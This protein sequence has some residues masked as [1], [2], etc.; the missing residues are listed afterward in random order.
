MKL[1]DKLLKHLKTDRNTFFTY[2]LTLISAYIIIDRVVEMIIMIFTGMGVD[3]W[4]PFVYTLAI[5]CPVFAYLFSCSSKYASND[6]VKHKLFNIFIVAFYIIVVS[7]F[8]QWLNLAG[9]ML[10]LSVPRFTDIVTNFYSLI[11]P[12]FSAIALYIPLTT[13]YG[14]IKW[15]VGTVNDTKDITDSLEDYGGINLSDKSASW[16]SYTC[17]MVFGKDKENGS[18]VKIAEEKRFYPT[19]VAGVSGSGKTSMIFEPMVAQDIDKKY[20]FKEISKEMGFTALKTGLATLNCPYSNDYINDNFSL[21]ML[22]PN[23]NKVGTYNTYM[24]KMII[25]NAGD[26]YIYKNLGI[27]YIS[28][29]IESVNHIKKVLKAY[30]LKYNLLDPSDS[31]SIGLNPFIYD[32]P[33][34]IAIAISLILKGT[35]VSVSDDPQY[36]FMESASK[37]IIENLVI[38]LKET[39]PIIHEGYLPTLE[40]LFECLNNYSKIEEL[41]EVLKSDEVLAKKYS[42]VIVF[43]ERYFYMSS[44]HNSDLQKYAEFVSAQLESLIRYPGVRNILCNRTNNVNFDNA[45]KDGEITLVCTRRGDLGPSI[46]RLFGLFVILLMQ[47]SV[48]RRTGDEK[49]RIPHF[50]YIDEFADFVCDETDTLFTLYRKYKV[51]TVVSIQNLAQLDGPTYGTNKKHRQVIT[52]N[53]S[54]K[55]VFGNN[56]PEDNEWWSQEIGDKKEW[57]YGNSYNTDKGEYDP[58]L[59]GIKY[60]NKI[61]YKPG[62]IQAVKFKQ[63]IYKLRNLSGKSDTGIA[64]LNFLSSSYYEDKKVKQYKFD[65]FNI[66]GSHIQGDDIEEK[67]NKKQNLSKYHFDDEDSATEVDPIKTDTSD[68]KFLF[69]NED[70][71]VINLKKNN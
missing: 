42:S 17:E 64:N 49:T 63:C 54:N 41:C 68:S 58:K 26:K 4:N 53:C 22:S 6:G 11:R 71:I 50:L 31:D 52:A 61:K 33:I 30:K 60:A 39:F 55:F 29:D 59:T 47:H 14:V 45:L 20:F 35:A 38:L 48:L 10:L 67:I 24:K 69:D 43:L 56:S 66:T 21:N 44:S 23:E 70:A 51:S 8:T 12:A 36:A 40:D 16:G 32:D 34:Q 1:L 13:F 7:M 46:H 18:T 3:Y 19:L 65:K 2:V 25:A 28:S 57:D 5:A 9:W 15:L 27:T 37:Q 62:K